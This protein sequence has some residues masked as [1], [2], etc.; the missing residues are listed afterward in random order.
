MSDIAPFCGSYILGYAEMRV[1]DMQTQRMDNITV[2][3]QL[4]PGVF[5]LKLKFWHIYDVTKLD[6]TLN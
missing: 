3:K 4:I 2:P 5:F 1:F 6:G